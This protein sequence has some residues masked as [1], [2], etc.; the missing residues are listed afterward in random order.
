MTDEP[1]K[2]RFNGLMDPVYPCREMPTRHCPAVYEAVCGESRP[3]ARFESN[4]ETPWLPELARPE[5]C[6]SCTE[7]G[8]ICT[9]T[10]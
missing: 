1:L 6:D 5:P 3:C 10:S 7:T 2:P 9:H 4:D 8:A